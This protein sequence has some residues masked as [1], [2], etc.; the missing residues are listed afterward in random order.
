MLCFFVLFFVITAV[1]RL[2]KLYL[3][4]SF[5]FHVNAYCC[6]LLSTLH[7]HIN[8]KPGALLKVVL[9]NAGILN[10]GLKSHCS[11]GVRC[12]PTPIHLLQIKIDPIAKVLY[13]DPIMLTQCVEGGNRLQP[14]GW[15]PSMTR[16]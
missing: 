12:F 11:G 9:F 6:F 10:V 3:F 2:K 16:I 8:I 15:W 13:N 14:A 7:S 5:C 1:L 4:S